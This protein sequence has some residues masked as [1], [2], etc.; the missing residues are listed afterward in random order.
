MYTREEMA[1]AAI[2]IL[3]S[4][5]S[6][7]ATTYSLFEAAKQVPKRLNGLHDQHGAHLSTRTGIRPQTCITSTASADSLLRALR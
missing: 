4:V 2:P 1:I 5:I 3:G 6:L 7:V